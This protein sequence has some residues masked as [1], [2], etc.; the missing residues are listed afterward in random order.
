MLN[1][2][3]I[4]HL[5]QYYLHKWS[6]DRYLFTLNFRNPNQIF[7]GEFITNTSRRIQDTA[8]VLSSTINPTKLLGEYRIKLAVIN[9]INDRI[10]E[11]K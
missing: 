6:Y 7:Y 3:S 5:K 4:E 9:M 2:N 8:R 11:E 1:F 10:K